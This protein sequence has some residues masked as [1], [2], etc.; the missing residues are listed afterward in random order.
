MKVRSWDECEEEERKRRERGKSGKAGNSKQ[1]RET[2]AEQGIDAK[3]K[4]HPKVSKVSL[5]IVLDLSYLVLFS[6]LVYLL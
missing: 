4:S 6:D 5:M 3:V 2:K 1:G